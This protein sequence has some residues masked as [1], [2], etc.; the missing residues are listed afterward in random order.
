VTEHLILTVDNLS[1]TGNVLL[2][3][4]QVTS[5]SLNTTLI[6][7]D[8]MMTHH[9]SVSPDGE[10]S[11]EESKPFDINEYTKALIEV[12]HAAVGLTK[13]VGA[14]GNMVTSERLTNRIEQLNN[15]AKERVEHAT[16]QSE[17]L[18]QTLFL[19]IVL[20]VI[21]IFMLLIGYHKLSFR[22]VSKAC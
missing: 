17:K 20:T 3:E 5:D 18:M 21:F 7:F 15:A 16:E 4:I 10:K 19:Y 1:G 2:K 8:K 6:T 11:S 9:F 22:Q 13:L 12:D 14:S